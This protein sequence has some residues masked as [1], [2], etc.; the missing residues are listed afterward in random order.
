MRQFTLND[1]Q[2]II[3]KYVIRHFTIENLR[4]EY[5]IAHKRIREILIK[6]N[7]KSRTNIRDFLN[8]DY[9]ENINTES[10]AYF[11]GYLLADGCISDIYKTKPGVNWRKRLSLD[12]QIRDIHI[13]EKLKNELNS[14]NKICLNKK[15]NSCKIAFTSSKLCNDLI[16]L[17]ITPRK[18]LTANFDIRKIP[19][20]LINHFIRGLFDGDGCVY[21][22]IKNNKIKNKRFDL[23]GS[24]EI[25][26]LFKQI[27][28][29]MAIDDIDKKIIQIG[30]IY[31]IRYNRYQSI[32]D[33]YNYIY[34]DATL[35]LNRKRNKFEEILKASA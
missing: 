8:E 11:L 7:I 26:N 23:C 9:F 6:N 21:F 2:D 30:K 3:N 16:N 35:F 28:N 27:L 12:L 18:S 19:N 14:S 15:R 29:S 33:F 10:K 13:L 32:K 4:K 22:Q 24:Y 34:S 20:H 31:R 5:K 17:G 25:C 1:E